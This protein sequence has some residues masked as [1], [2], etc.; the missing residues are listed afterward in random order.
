MRKTFLTFSILVLIHPLNTMALEAES[1]F[2]G[3]MSIQIGM[4]KS[5]VISTLS[6]H[7]ILQK[8]NPFEGSNWERWNI[9]KKSIEGKPKGSVGTVAFEKDK[10]VW[11]SKDWGSFYEEEAVSFVQAFI[12]AV[13]SLTEEEKTVYV[14]I[15]KHR[16]PGSYHENITFISGNHDITINLWDDKQSGKGVG[17]Q[18]DIR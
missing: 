8:L 13:S 17:I 18:E 9:I 15:R 1:L 2:V 4:D 14:Q 11:V 16:E 5:K 7:C 6:E 10:V 12:G 3:S